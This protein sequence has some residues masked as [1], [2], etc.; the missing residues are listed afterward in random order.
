MPNVPD[1]SR[2]NSVS[3]AIKIDSRT[4]ETVNV[5]TGQKVANNYDQLNAFLRKQHD[6]GT[7]Q[8]TTSDLK[9]NALNNALRR[10]RDQSN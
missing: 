6:G 4:G 9:T 3:F 5:V 7:Y 1:L 2:D 10:L 8:N